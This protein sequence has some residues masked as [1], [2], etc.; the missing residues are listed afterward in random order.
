MESADKKFKIYN[1]FTKFNNYNKS[2]KFSSNN[3][4]VNSNNF[5]NKENNKQ[6]IKCFFC[7]QLGHKKKDC[8][9]K[10]QLS[11]EVNNQASYVIKNQDN[12]CINDNSLEIDYSDL[13]NV[14]YNNN[15][16]EE[17][18]YSSNQQC[19][20]VSREPIEYSWWTLDSGASN[21]LTQNKNLLNVT[22]R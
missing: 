11:L 13:F 22:E 12:D 10:K 20:N 7:N 21:H 15:F 3:K 16:E 4:R 2:A 17:P 6:N 1:K 8:K 18:T 9:I 14:D 5:K 19:N